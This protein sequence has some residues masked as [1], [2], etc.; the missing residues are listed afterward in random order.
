MANSF[1]FKH[2]NSV[3]MGSDY[4]MGGVCVNTDYDLKELTCS[5]VIEHTKKEK[6]N[7]FSWYKRFYDIKSCI[8]ICPLWIRQVV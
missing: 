6:E 2:I 8:L 5:L 7:F 1:Y 3:S 4:I